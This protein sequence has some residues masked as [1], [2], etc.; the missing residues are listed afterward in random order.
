MRNLKKMETGLTGDQIAVI[1]IGC[2]VAVAVIVLIIVFFVLKRKND[3][4]ESRDMENSD[5]QNDYS[6]FIV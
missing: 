2:I 6:S 3:N 1:V 4:G 5:Y